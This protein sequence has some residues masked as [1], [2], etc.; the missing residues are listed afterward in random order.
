MTVD[1]DGNITT[2][3]RGLHLLSQ[4]VLPGQLAGQLQFTT[5]LNSDI[6]AIGEDVIRQ[7]RNGV[8]PAM[9]QQKFG[10]Q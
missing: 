5:L 3:G 1:Q 6:I 8:L 2:S 7:N 10:N 4:G 9:F